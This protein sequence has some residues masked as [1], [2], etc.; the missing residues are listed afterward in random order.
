MS[1]LAQID[2]SSLV[3]LG[4]DAAFANELKLYTNVVYGF[5]SK[6]IE[7]TLMMRYILTENHN[8]KS[9]LK[10]TAL[11]LF[12]DYCKVD[13]RIWSTSTVQG[14]VQHYHLPRCKLQVNLEKNINGAS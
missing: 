5:H 8:C 11:V 1:S 3:C 2:Q 10:D 12:W 6:T 7:Y 4:S 13:M 14:S 9:I